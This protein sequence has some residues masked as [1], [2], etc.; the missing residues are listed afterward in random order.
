MNI[1]TNI[2]IIPFCKFLQLSSTEQEAYKPTNQQGKPCDSELYVDGEEGEKIMQKIINKFDELATTTIMRRCTRFLNQNVN[3]SIH[4]R[5]Y[6]IVSKTRHYTRDRICY[7]AERAF[8][9]HNHGYLGASLYQKW[10]CFSQEEILELERNDAN[11]L[12]KAQNTKKTRS[13]K[14]ML[15]DEE[16]NY[17]S[18]FGFEDHPPLYN[19]DEFSERHNEE[20]H[21][22]P[23]DAE[24]DEPDEPPKD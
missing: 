21:Q 2:A 10:D 18:G 22:V 5:L 23:K 4:S 13:A 14:P 11:M 9:V 24:D 15:K 7:A 3:E 20:W 1:F 19:L 12:L 6:T 17:S 8:M 16:I